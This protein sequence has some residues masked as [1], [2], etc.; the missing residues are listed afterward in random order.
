VFVGL[1]ADAAVILQ[2]YAERLVVNHRRGDDTRTAKA[3]RRGI[4]I[5]PDSEEPT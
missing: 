2:T 3:H 1:A 4:H 5:D